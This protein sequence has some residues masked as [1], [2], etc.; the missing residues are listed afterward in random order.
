MAR[1][2]PLVLLLLGCARPPEAGPLV[3]L[4]QVRLEEEAPLN[5]AMA[6]IL[7][8]KR[9]YPYWTLAQ[10][11]WPEARV[12]GR[13]GYK[14]V[15]EL[16]QKG[17]ADMAFLCT[18]AAAKAVAEGY[19]EVI[20]SSVPAPWTR[21]RSVI[22]VR[23]DSQ[24]ASLMDL[25][26]A[27]MAFVDPLSN[28]G[29]IRPIQALKKLGYRPEA[30]LGK[31]LFTYAHDR[32]VEAVIRGLVEAA[33]V[34]GMVLDALE[35]KNPELKARIRVIWEGPEDPPPPVVVRKGLAPE[36]QRVLL[37]RLQEAGQLPEAGIAGFVPANSG[38]YRSFL[39]GF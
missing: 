23:A 6:G 30:Y 9:S 18:F 34:D 22:I 16:L 4:P 38:V 21:Y 35:R 31:V 27:T 17:Q 26:G 28:T 29:Y 24:R 14:E 33:A 12:L 5:I 13:R 39:E 36:V 32:A 15:L 20:A 25:A 37:Q 7:S 8:P 3:P 11:L 10:T 1:V 2:W 19:G